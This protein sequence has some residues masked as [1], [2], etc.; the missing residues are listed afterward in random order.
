M[1]ETAFMNLSEHCDRVKMDKKSQKEIR[2]LLVESRKDLLET[3]KAC[4]DLQGG[5][6]IETAISSDAA[7]AKI[8]ARKVQPDVIVCGLPIS[9]ADCLE[10]L[11]VLRHDGYNILFIVFSFEFEN[12]LVVKSFQLGADGF[13]RRD[14]DPEKVYSNLRRCIDSLMNRTVK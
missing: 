4:L 5:L 11:R 7:L 3:V 10:F 14:G 1:E 6:D 9:D 12:E 13:V 8:E 2:V